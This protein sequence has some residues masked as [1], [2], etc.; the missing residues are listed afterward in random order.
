MAVARLPAAAPALGVSGLVEGLTP[1]LHARYV[2]LLIVSWAFFVLSIWQ[3]GP[4]VI[5]WPASLGLLSYLHWSYWLALGVLLLTALLAYLDRAVQSNLL[6]ITITLTL[7]VYLLGLTVFLEPNARTPASYGN[8]SEVSVIQTTGRLDLG[9]PLS[10][11]SYRN[12]PGTL[13]LL[14]GAMD[15]TGIEDYIQFTKYLPLLWPFFLVF[16]TQGIGCRLGL[17]PKQRFLVSFLSLS[18]TLGWH[19]YPATFLGMGLYF[20]A[21][22]LL[23]E[24][25]RTVPTT[26]MLIIVA[27]GL[28]IIHPIMTLALLLTAIGLFLARGVTNTFLL[29]LI[30]LVGAWNLY[31]ALSFTD[32]FINNFLETF[33]R[34]MVGAQFQASSYE[35]VGPTSAARLASRYSQIAFFAIY[36]LLILRHVVWLLRRGRTDPNGALALQILVI[37]I[38]LGPIAVGIGLGGEGFAR[39][40]VLGSVWIIV[41]LVLTRPARVIPAALMLVLPVGLLFAQYSLE[42]AWPYVSTSSLRGTEFLATRV[43]TAPANFFA[44]HGVHDLASYYNPEYLSVSS[45]DSWSVTDPARHRADA[46]Q[47]DGAPYALFNRQGHDTML[48]LW[49]Y[50]PFWQWRYSDAGAQADLIYDSNRFEIYKN[51]SDG[52]R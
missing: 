45:M 13:Y 43:E 39:T 6:F 14:A 51:G 11:S 24:R 35:T 21:V 50:D 42:G 32:Y 26:I 18:T 44:Y 49:G 34:P 47:L 37:P 28:V 33:W 19:D 27:L 25:P 40:L 1:A 23:L 30:A 3:T 4:V 12:W 15:I 8:F 7:G 16:I 36:A 52:K 46:S 20:L 22:M 17:L 9:E 48:W 41:V 31:A 38:V 5:E 10:P 2:G 29:L